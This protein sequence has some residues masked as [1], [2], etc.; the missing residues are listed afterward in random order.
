M[1]ANAYKLAVHGITAYDLISGNA[2]RKIANILSPEEI[3]EATHKH[4]SYIICLEDGK[5]V[6]YLKCHLKRLGMT[7]HEYI[8]KWQLPNNYSFVA[9]ASV[10]GRGKKAWRSR[11]RNAKLA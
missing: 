5:H 11:R 3:A 8:T 10:K 9:R 4:S 6:K 2:L 7:P 1:S